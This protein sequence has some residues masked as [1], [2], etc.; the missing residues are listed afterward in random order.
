MK[1]MFLAFVVEGVVVHGN[2]AEGG[3]HKQSEGAQESVTV[4]GGV[5]AEYPSGSWA[6]KTARLY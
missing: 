3:V 6:F 4:W 5:A 1:A 2:F